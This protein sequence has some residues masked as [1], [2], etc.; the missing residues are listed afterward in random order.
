MTNGHP[1]TPTRPSRRRPGTNILKAFKIF[2]DPKSEHKS[3]SYQHLG[4]EFQ[5]V[6]KGKVEVMV[7][8]NK[9]V[10]GPGQSIHFNSAI[11][12]RLKNISA[13]RAELVVV[14]YTP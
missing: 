2:I 1:P 8:E 10:L 6:L 4:E 14:L 12:H 3:V 9:N 7:G 13:K 11:P 5:Y